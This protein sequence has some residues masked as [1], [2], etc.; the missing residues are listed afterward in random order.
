[1]PLEDYKVEHP[2]YQYIV[3]KTVPQAEKVALLGE[4]LV[5]YRDSEEYDFQNSSNGGENDPITYFIAFPRFDGAPKLLIQIPTGETQ[6]AES[7]AIQNAWNEI[8][9]LSCKLE[10]RWNGSVYHVAKR[11]SLKCKEMILEEFLH[12]YEG[13]QVAVVPDYDGGKALQLTAGYG[14][15]NTSLVLYYQ[16]ERVGEKDRMLAMV[17][18]SESK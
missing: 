7:K 2:D 10:D 8:L 5:P 9:Q 6:R 17:S 11:R 3:P 18:E 14:S 16:P 4:F 15:S 1:M 12:K 13:F